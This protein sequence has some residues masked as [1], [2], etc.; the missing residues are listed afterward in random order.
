MDD[1]EEEAARS[2]AGGGRRR[3]GRPPRAGAGRGGGGGGA[4]GLR[5]PA[6]PPRLSAGRFWR[7]I[8]MLAVLVVVAVATQRNGFQRLSDRLFG[9]PVNWMNDYS[10]STHLYDMIASS[11]VTDV[12]KACLLLNI[13]GGDPANATVMDVFERP[14]E[15]CMG[16]SHDSVRVLPR[17]F[18]LRVDRTTGRVQSDS[19]TPGVF[20]PLT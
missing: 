7:R 15:A 3:D 11:H 13:H 20:R 1:D 8:G 2:L 12:P 19:G 10:M 17:L 18:Q 16:P 6:A 4:A 9:A 14:T 5:L